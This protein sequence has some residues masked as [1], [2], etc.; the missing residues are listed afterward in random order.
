MNCFY[1][2][3]SSPSE[4]HLTAVSFYDSVNSISASAFNNGSFLTNAEVIYI[5]NATLW[6]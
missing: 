2:S 4:T 1:V 6:N 5:Y 3:G